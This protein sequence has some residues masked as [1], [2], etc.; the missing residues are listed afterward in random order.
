MSG[1]PIGFDAIAGLEPPRLALDGIAKGY[2]DVAVIEDVSLT[3]ARGEFVALV[4]PSGCG[5][6]TLLKIIAGL[7]FPDA[8]HVRIADTEVTDRRA[9]E[10]DVAMVFQS[11]ALY[12]HLTARQNL[13]LPLLMRRTSAWQRLPLVG[14]LLPG[15]GPELARIAS[16]VEKAARALK[17]DHLLDRKPAA[18]SGGQRQRVALGRA[19]VRDPRLFLMD[20]PLSNLDASLRVHTRAEIVELH[21]AL[22]ATTVYVTHDQEEALGMADRV[23]VMHRGRLM[24]VASPEVIYRDPHRIEVAEF[25]GSPKIN[26]IAAV[27]DD[28]GRAIAF[29]HPLV[30]GLP[31]AP[32]APLGVGIRPEHL[33]L[34]MPEAG[35]LICRLERCEFLGA[36]AIAH[37]HLPDGGPIVARATPEAFRHLAPG[38]VGLTWRPEDVLVFDAAGDRLRPSPVAA[39]VEECVHV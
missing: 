5:K 3:V 24:Q 11:Y 38:H 4:G 32:A 6:S 9:A 12:P 7:E 8:G 27:A 34:G 20:E 25:I 13:A 17:I 19:M 29:G 22:G 39:A 1:L 23:A 28:R 21:R 26:M 18:M 16:D 35:R 10:R 14:R 36:D 31:A 33:R 37:L 30:S 15:T 2:G